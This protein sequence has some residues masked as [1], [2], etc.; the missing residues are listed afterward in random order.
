MTEPLN[1]LLL[2]CLWSGVVVCVCLVLLM[3]VGAIY[4]ISEK[5]AALL[6]VA[7]ATALLFLV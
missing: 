6:V 4:C 1:T 5:A 3:L 7:V 2:I